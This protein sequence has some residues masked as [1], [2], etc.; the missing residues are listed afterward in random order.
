MERTS[1]DDIYLHKIGIDDWQLWRK[2]RL[3]A[4]AEAPYAF[5]S[6]LADWQGQGD[7]ETRWRGRLS[8]VPLNIIAEWRETPAG[9]TSATAPHPDGSVELLSMWVAPFARGHGV[10][11]SLV[12]AVIVWARELQASRVALAVCEG[13]ERAL[14]LYR[15]HG[16]MDVGAA[17]G[18]SSGTAN[19][20]KLVRALE[21]LS[22]GVVTTALDSGSPISST[23]ILSYLGWELPYVCRCRKLALPR[24]TAPEGKVEGHRGRHSPALGSRQLAPKSPPR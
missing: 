20:R 16:F 1:Q 9:R 21:R 2:L 3:E 11:D 22:L 5:G 4:L 6:K 23:G 7:T 24:E 15:R 10:G 14:A 17:P 13:N 8:D 18:T 12:N 19:E